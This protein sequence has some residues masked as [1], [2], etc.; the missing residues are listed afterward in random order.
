VSRSALARV[1]LP[2]LLGAIWSTLGVARTVTDHLRDANLLRLSVAAL[3]LG[4]GAIASGLVLRDP[5]SRNLRVVAALLG[6]GAFY[7]AVVLPMHNPEEKAHFVEY[8]LVALLAWGSCPVGW[9]RR[10][11]F[12]SAALFTLCAGWIDEGI[13]ALIPSRHYDLRD[14]AFNAAAGLLALSAL[15]VLRWVRS[16]ALEPDTT[17]S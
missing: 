3:F 15:S 5:R 8:G 14:V 10:R 7:A 11:R 6:L 17:S 1:A 2:L 9:T 16:G 4:A 13:Q 12:V